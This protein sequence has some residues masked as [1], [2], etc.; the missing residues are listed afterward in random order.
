MRLMIIL[1]GAAVL[2]LPATAA[3]AHGAAK[4]KPHTAASVACSKQADAHG[5]HGS[6]RKKFRAGC[7]S[8]FKA[9]ART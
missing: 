1:A 2:A 5:L 8:K 7:K 9:A 4:S 3:L 6:A